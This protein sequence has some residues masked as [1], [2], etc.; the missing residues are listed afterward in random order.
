MHARP[1]GPAEELPPLMNMDGSRQSNQANDNVKA[2]K[3]IIYFRKI[4]VSDRD[5][6]QGLHESW[7]PVDYKPSFFDSL[8]SGDPIMTGK[9]SRS[10]L[11]NCVAC[12][13]ELTDKEFD[14][15]KRRSAEKVN[16]F[17]SNSQG[18]DED[19]DEE[20]FILWEQPSMPLKQSDRGYRT[21]TFDDDGLKQSGE[22]PMVN[23]K[24]TMVSAHSDNER[25]RIESFYK[26]DFRFDSKIDESLNC[27][28]DS[29]YNEATGE[30]IIGCVVG[31]F[32]SSTYPSTQHISSLEEVP[33]RDETCRLL[34]P[35]GYENR[36]SRMFY[37]MTLGTSR[38]FRR[39]GLGSMLVKRVIDLVER[40]H[41]CGALYLHVITYNKTGRC[42]E[43]CYSKSTHSPTQTIFQQ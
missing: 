12:F 37:I 19:S 31:T 14:M 39:I 9:S 7:F 23:G 10:P 6:I 35:D 28:D 8:C 42:C 2:S 22:D 25:T 18:S 16:S 30:Q 29:H 15:R 36:Y 27:Q 3:G 33:R 17:W 26:N 1:A 40:T 41:D 38:E 13:R 4:R 34:V 5:A 21:T 11:F 43:I 24:T 20:D 32:V